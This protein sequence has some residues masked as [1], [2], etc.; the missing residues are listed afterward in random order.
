[1]ST[2]K[3]NN[4]LLSHPTGNANVRGA[5]NALLEQG[6][7]ESFHTSV[8]CFQ[9]NPLYFIAMGPLKDFRR[10]EFDKRL[11][12]KT[13]THPWKELGRMAFAKL[14]WK[15]LVKHEIGCCCVD[16]VYRCIDVQ[17]AR[18]V[19]KQHT[20]IDAI[21]AY[22]DCALDTFQAAKEYRKKCFY[23]LP[24][25][26]WRAMRELLEEERQKN[27]AWAMTLGGFNDSETKQ[28]RKDQELTLADK[29][30]VAS[31]FT[32]RTLELYP[33][34]LP[35]I[36][37]IPY[38]F[39][40]VNMQR[41]YIPFKNRKIKILFVGGLSQRKGLSYLF[42]ALKGLEKAV[43]LTVIGGGN[44]E[45]CPALKAALNK[46]YY[47]PSLSH[48][49]VLNV[50]AKHDLLVFPSLFEGFGLVITE[51]MSQG[52]PV[53]TTERT[54]GPDVITNSKDGWIVPAG[55]VN[56][57][58]KLLEELIAQP[59]MLQTVGEAA[60]QTAACRPWKRYGEDLLRFIK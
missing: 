39:P 24:I 6:I 42:N 2:E 20:Q 32:K 40:P 25:G 33:G 12:G 57:I 4:I 48:Q 16:A 26:Y 45:Q 3:I 7:L 8:A 44:V 47:M 53:I 43:E 38:G 10:R 56:P 29:I 5:L 21:Y 28:N 15:T 46:V 58:R 9:G 35:E 54:C 11:Q 55:T 1:M 27:P 31:T 19:Q 17:V 30:F 52:T 37:V 49:E 41:K 59:A 34:K 51:A 18:Y 60:R 50:M 36:V 23:E 13:H 14:G 22:E